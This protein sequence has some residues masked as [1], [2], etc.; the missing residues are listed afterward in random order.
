MLPQRLC[1]RRELR[2]LGF[3]VVVVRGAGT[4][5]ERFV[6]T[7]ALAGIIYARVVAAGTGIAGRGISAAARGSARGELG[8]T[9]S[10]RRRAERFVVKAVLAFEQRIVLQD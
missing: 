8:A 10:R 7:I 9:A 2:I 6:E 1:F 4:V 5:A 3:V